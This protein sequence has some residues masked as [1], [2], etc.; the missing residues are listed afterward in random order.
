MNSVQVSVQYPEKLSRGILLLKTFL[1]WI[2][3]IPHFFCLGFVG[4]A[5]NFVAFISWFAVLFTGKYPQ[6]LFNFMVGTMDWGMRIGAYYGLLRDEYPTFGFKPGYPAGVKVTYPEK[7]S[8]GQLLLRTF[9]GFFYI[10]IPHGFCLFL[11]MIACGF[12]SL[13]AWW[14]I[15]FTGKIPANM[16]SFISGTFRWSINVGAYYLFLTDEY[17]PFTGKATG[18]AAA[19]TGAAV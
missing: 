17:P 14:V 11:R 9:F 19:G 18:S 1:G 6:S 12:V 2:I 3:L 16:F 8:R 5:A 4:M 7:L 15:L 13:I 10:L